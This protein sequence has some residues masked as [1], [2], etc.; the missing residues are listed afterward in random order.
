M[1]NAIKEAVQM[2]M[3]SLRFDHYQEEEIYANVNQIVDPNHPSRNIV[4]V[5]YRMLACH[6]A[7]TAT[8]LPVA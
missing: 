4:E 6:S 5:L 7:I 3:D 8:T 1:F 2:Q